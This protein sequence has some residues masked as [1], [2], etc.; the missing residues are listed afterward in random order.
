MPN[1][2]LTGCLGENVLGGLPGYTGFP[3]R[4]RDKELEKLPVNLRV[5]MR[6][7]GHERET[8]RGPV[9]LDKV[10]KERLGVAPPG[11]VQRRLLGEAPDGAALL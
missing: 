10:R 1:S 5:H 3:V 9:Y 8:C 11:A 7:R 6:A 2:P 4:V